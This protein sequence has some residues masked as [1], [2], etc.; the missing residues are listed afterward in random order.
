MSHIKQHK[1]YSEKQ[2]NIQKISFF[3]KISLIALTIFIFI[4]IKTTELFSKPRKNYRLSKKT[5]QKMTVI[6]NKKTILLKVFKSFQKQF[7][8]S[9]LLTSFSTVLLKESTLF[10]TTTI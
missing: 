1:V 2:Q 9:V 10:S 4:V 5:Y 8:F 3:Y 6:E 7:W